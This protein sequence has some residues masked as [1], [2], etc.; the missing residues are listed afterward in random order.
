MEIDNIRSNRPL[1]SVQDIVGFIDKG[2]KYKEKLLK[3]KTIDSEDILSLLY[4]IILTPDYQRQYR[5]TSSEESTIIESLIVG[6]PIPE[7]FLVKTKDQ[8]QLRHVMDGQHRLTAIYRFIKNKYR[9]NSLEILDRDENGVLV[10]EPRFEGKFFSELDLEFQLKILGSHISVLEFEPFDNPELEIELFKRYNKN[11]KP[12]EIH[13]ISMATFYSKTSQY[14]SQ[15]INQVYDLKSQEGSLI[16]Y[17]S[18]EL[19]KLKQIYNINLNRKN[20]QKNHQEICVILN[21]LER[22]DTIKDLNLKDSIKLS[23]NYLEE[24]SKLYKQNLES[25]DFTLDVFS[26]FNKLVLKLSDYVDNPISMQLI[27]NSNLKSMKYHT[28]ISIILAIIV[29]LF[30]VDLESKYLVD[31]LQ[32]IIGL[33]PIGDPN[34]RASSTNLRQVLTYLVTENN[35][36]SRDFSSLT[37]K[38]QSKILFENQG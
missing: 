31:D 33:S 19:F 9:L 27:E 14:I 15:F 35:I 13:E 2:E 23:S 30:E 20:K 11:S 7:I 38:T 16:S 8:V 6:I 34:Y 1:I 37:L 17:S 21:I 36:L 5:S 28:G 26:N 18:D 24:K 10:D 3:N 4:A 29:Y 25:L 12:L 22:F 32:E